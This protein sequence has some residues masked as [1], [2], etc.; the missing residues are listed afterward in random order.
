MNYLALLLTVTAACGGS[1]RAG[2]D[3]DTQPDAAPAC[4]AGSRTIAADADWTLRGASARSLLASRAGTDDAVHLALLD[5]DGPV[6]LAVIPGAARYAFSAALAEKPDGTRCAV[7]TSSIAGVVLA[8]EGAQ[9]ETTMFDALDADQPPVPVWSADGTLSVFAQTYA[10]FTELRRTPDG[11]WSDIEEY[12]SSI[13]FPTDAVATAG[14]PV[15][16]FI[17]AG[18]YPVVQQGT[19]QI[20]STVVSAVKLVPPLLTTSATVAAESAAVADIGPTTRC[21]DDPRSAYATSA[22]GAA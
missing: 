22:T 8:C 12:E 5:G 9:P 16:C 3:D 13:S 15:V 2:D 19:A 4:T 17:S 14:G 1:S 6:E 10:A 20:A 21:R 18:G 7:A 11:A